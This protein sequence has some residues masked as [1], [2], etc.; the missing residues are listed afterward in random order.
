MTNPRYDHGFIV[1]GVEVTRLLPTGFIIIL[2]F[3]VAATCMMLS[4]VGGCDHV[5]APWPC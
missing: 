3:M 4:H 5:Y 2:L 1:V